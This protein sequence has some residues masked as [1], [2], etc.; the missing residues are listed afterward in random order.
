MNSA[1]ELI[2]IGPFAGTNG[3]EVVFNGTF[4]D[5]MSSSTLT[6]EFLNNVREIKIPEQR[7]KWNN[8]IE[9][10]NVRFNN[11]QR[12]TTKIPLSALTVVTGVSGSGKTSLIK[13][14]FYPL[15]LRSLGSVCW[16][17]TRR[18]RRYSW[19]HFN[20]SGGRDD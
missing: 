19:R 14:V 1:D 10:K 15:I 20:G 13:G 8:F 4:D 9:V 7:R 16:Y 6:S 17:Q 2:D 5:M 11:L 3:G 18:I 12:V